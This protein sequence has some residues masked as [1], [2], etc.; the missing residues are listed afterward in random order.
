MTSMN[1]SHKEKRQKQQNCKNKKEQKVCIY[2]EN[3]SLLPMETVDNNDV[4]KGGTDSELLVM[5]LMIN[6]TTTTK[7]LNSKHSL[8]GGMTLPVQP[9]IGGILDEQFS[10]NHFIKKFS[11]A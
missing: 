2:K 3:R 9:Q 11:S 10:H 1:S 4:K 6:T 7:T 5:L 8:I